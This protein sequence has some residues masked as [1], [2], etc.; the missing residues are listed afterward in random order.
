MGRYQSIHVASEGSVNDIFERCSTFDRHVRTYICSCD[1]NFQARFLWIRVHLHV[2]E[3]ILNA[4][5]HVHQ[6][7][8]LGLGLP[9]V[10][11]FHVLGHVEEPTII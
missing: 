3:G 5:I 10:Q 4:G 6:T 1:L 11:R 9:H 8:G 7:M 2:H